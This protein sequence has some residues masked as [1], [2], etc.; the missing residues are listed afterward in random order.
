M[1]FGAVIPAFLLSLPIAAAVLLYVYR[2][3]GSGSEIRVATVLLLKRISRPVFAP[4]KIKLPPR[5]FLELLIASL[6]ATAAAGLYL[7]GEGGLHILLI[8]NSLSM[9]AQ[10][11]V[12]AQSESRL[13]RAKTEAEKTLASLSLG[14]QVSVFLTSPGLSNISQGFVSIAEARKLISS[15]QVSYAGD[16][17]RPALERLLASTEGAPVTVL[18]DQ[19]IRV[20]GAAK[21]LSAPTSIGTTVGNIAISSLRL[22][23]E[24]HGTSMT[25]LAGIDAFV[26][27]SAR[28]SKEGIPVLVSLE[29][30]ETDPNVPGEV[31]KRPRAE[32]KQVIKHGERLEI[33]FENVSRGSQGFRLRLSGAGATNETNALR[34]DDEVYFLPRTNKGPLLVVSDL[35]AEALGL[36]ALKNYPGKAITPESFDVSSVDS[37]TPLVVLHRVVPKTLPTAPL[38]LILPPATS[39]L[40]PSKL[41]KSPGQITRWLEGHPINSYVQYGPLS[42]KEQSVL[43][44]PGWAQEIVSSTHGPLLYAGE[45]EGRRVVVS[46]LELLPFEGK[47]SPLLSILTLNIFKWLSGG[48]GDAPYSSVF[49]RIT[50]PP[51]SAEPRMFPRSELQSNTPEATVP[52]KPGLLISL[53]QKGKPE[54]VEA[55]NF[56]DSSESDTAASTSLAITL[57]EAADSTQASQSLVRPLS[58]AA[59]ILLLVDTLFWFLKRYR[60][61]SHAL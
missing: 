31:T 21:R 6:L 9:G 57:P 42:L 56:F 16:N 20:E 8:D 23:E 38:L 37:S 59:L 27:E 29:E 44:V 36:A 35:G 53:G 1:P 2:R 52:T 26:P 45:F 4:R 54:I 17:L 50:L 25:A 11:T 18:T 7:Q 47:K 39:S 43:Q 55:I 14:A 49:S 58:L 51:K 19:R 12:G 41:E 40:F 3:G 33:K 22:R 15:V 30:L 24:N 5:F 28:S 10:S 48:T 61:R 32:K 46:G 60:G 13:D 34:E